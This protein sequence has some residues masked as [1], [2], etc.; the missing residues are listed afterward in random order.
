[1]ILTKLIKAE[2]DL[3]EN[4]KIFTSGCKFYKSLELF[5]CVLEDSTIFKIPKFTEIRLK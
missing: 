4:E 5:D 2:L 3:L 1:M